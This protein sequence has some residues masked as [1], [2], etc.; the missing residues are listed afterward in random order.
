MAR[1]LRNVSFVLLACTMLFASAEKVRADECEY[2]GFSTSSSQQ[3]QEWAQWLCNN[4]EGNWQDA[5]NFACG[6]SEW[7]GQKTEGSCS[8]VS[9]CGTENGQ[10]VWCSSA[11]LIC[12]REEL[13]L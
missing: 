2:P 13:E 3:S 12:Y 5:C 1:V 7:H 6:G 8:T 10:P 4:D 9:Q 11:T